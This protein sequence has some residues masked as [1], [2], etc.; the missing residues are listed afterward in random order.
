MEAPGKGISGSGMG[1]GVSA[2]ST[3]MMLE[4]YRPGIMLTARKRRQI[5]VPQ[6]SG[7]K[8]RSLFSTHPSHI[9]HWP[10]SYGIADC[11]IHHRLSRC[12]LVLILVRFVTQ[13]VR[14]VSQYIS[15]QSVDE[16]FEFLK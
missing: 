7:V 6:G 16:N 14:S 3:A 10:F 1:S 12:P 15:E 5:S 8:A 4:S 9:S 11:S 13:N 2:S